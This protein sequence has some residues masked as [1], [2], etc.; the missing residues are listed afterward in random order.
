MIQRVL[1]SI[2]ISLLVQWMVFDI[3]PPDV[4]DR[5]STAMGVSVEQLFWVAG[6][7][8]FIGVTI[9]LVTWLLAQTVVSVVGIIATL[10]IGITALACFP[11]PAFETH[12]D[13]ATDVDPTTI[14]NPA[15]QPYSAAQPEPTTQCVPNEFST[16]TN[17]CGV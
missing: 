5:L 16:P 17:P 7:L 14:V 6:T 9:A 2:A 13:F 11:P 4:A 10:V 15:Q 3:A 1:I 8:I 12:H